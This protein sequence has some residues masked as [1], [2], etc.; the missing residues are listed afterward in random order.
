M[1]NDR[2][3]ATIDQLGSLMAGTRLDQLGNATPCTDWT[4]RDLANHL[5]GGGH[6]FAACFRGETV[7]PP[8]AAPDLVGDDPQAAFMA[9]IEDFR[10]S[11]TRQSARDA[12]VVLPF[13]T[14]PGPVALDVATLDL[15]VHSW[16]LATSTDQRF[17][18]EEAAVEEALAAARQMVPADGRDPAVFGPAVEVSASAPAIERL[19]GWLGRRPPA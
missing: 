5:V 17:R 19:V 11:F 2:L 4:V 9:S 12:M 16:D 7:E 1:L 15:I 13:G 10:A 6:L 8:A 14:L 18:P 3:D